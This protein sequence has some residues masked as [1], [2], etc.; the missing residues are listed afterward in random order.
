MGKEKLTV[1]E[2]EPSD[3]ALIVAYWLE[4]NP[5]HHTAMGVDLAKMPSG[6]QLTAMISEQLTQSYEQKKAYCIIWEIDGKPV[7]HSN[8]NKII[9]GEEAYMHL[10]LWHSS[11]R[12]KGAGSAFVQMTIP[13]FFINMQLKTLYCEPY[14][15]NPAANKTLE[16]AGFEFVKEHITIPGA[17]NFEQPVY[18]WQLTQDRYRELF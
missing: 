10:H 18:L 5:A 8:V 17:L 7:G 1:R 3:V 2:I 12:Q 11:T 6:E 16:K 4:S 13:W 15:L 14:K 9:F